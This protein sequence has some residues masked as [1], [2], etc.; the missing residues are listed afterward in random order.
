LFI[1]I[2]AAKAEVVKAIT[3]GLLLEL[4]PGHV[5]SQGAA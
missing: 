4:A 1:L 3:K 2:A 5:A